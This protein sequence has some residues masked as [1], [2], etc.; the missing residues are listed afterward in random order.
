MARALSALA[1]ALV[2]QAL[3]VERNADH[4]V[5]WQENLPSIFKRAKDR[6]STLSTA[7]ALDVVRE[8][9]PLEVLQVLHAKFTGRPLS[10]LVQEEQKSNSTLRA[11][12]QRKDKTKRNGHSDSNS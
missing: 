11:V 3:T 4:N 10:G 5:A 12:G 1:C 7:A 2:A 8:R 6:A 9:L